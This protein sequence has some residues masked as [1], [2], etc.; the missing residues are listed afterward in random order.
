MPPLESTER[1]DMRSALPPGR[2]SLPRWYDLFGLRPSSL[3]T[4]VT[5]QCLLWLAGGLL[6]LGGCWAA[7][8]ASSPDARPAAAP[9]NENASP[10][11]SA[12][13]AQATP[14]PAADATA[15]SE[16]PIASPVDRPLPPPSA[17]HPI[18]Q[19]PEGQAYRRALEAWDAGDADTAQRIANELAGHPTYSPLAVAIEAVG[20]IKRGELEKA[21]ELAEQISSIPVMQREAYAIAGEVFQRRQEWTRAEDAFLHALAIDPYHVRSHR[22]L[23]V[24]YYDS[25]AMRLATEHL[26]QVAWLEPQECKSLMLSARIY[27]DYEQ[28]SEAIEDLR[29]LL[30]RDPPTDMAVAAKIELAHCYTQLRRLEDAR[31]VLADCPSEL[32]GVLAMRAAVA[33]AEGD[34]EEAARLARDALQRGSP[35]KAALVL[36]RVLV[37]QGQWQA[38]VELLEPLVQQTPSDHRF[39]MLLGRAALRRRFLIDPARSFLIG[40]QPDKDRT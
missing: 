40:R 9:A 2:E 36:G 4:A 5:G 8:Q 18:D 35:A 15:V 1:P 13:A 6:S 31:K 34:F 28:Y 12:P 29:A 37:A 33:E 26:R 32:P 39:R 10:D 3:Q 22:W 30:R 27:I 25:G 24:L 19:I 20:H 17:R 23:A 21:L 11:L 14:S 7:P 38:A 16:E